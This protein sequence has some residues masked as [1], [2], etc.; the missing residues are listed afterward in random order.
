MQHG[1]E[2][3]VSG[4]QR[5]LRDQLADLRRIWV[6]DAGARVWVKCA[7]GSALA[8]ILVAILVDV[9]RFFDFFHGDVWFLSLTVDRSLPELVMDT[10]ALTAAMLALVMFR[11]TGLRGFFFFAVV[12]GYIIVDDFFSLHEN[13]GA[14]LVGR[15]RL[16]DFGLVSGQD[17][18]EL[19]AY[20]I[21]GVCLLPLC[22]WSVRGFR[23]P[24]LVVLLL[25]GLLFAM[26]VFFAAGMDLVHAIVQ[27][28]AMHR[29][30]GW[31]EDGG[32]IVSISLMTALAILQSR[33][34]RFR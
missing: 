18:G 11:R 24:D 10:L 12:L 5:E 13:M 17:E 6:S 20:G 3:S 19:L 1:L 32:E 9:A 4:F 28:K 7:I 16:A 26:F 21:V 30:L 27:N 22:Y 23:A 8:V 34:A 2:L 31:V 25:Y 15:L 33:S 29:V 14:F